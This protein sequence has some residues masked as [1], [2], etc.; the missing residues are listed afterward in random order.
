V[1]G[2]NTLA[3]LLGAL[4]CQAVVRM[5]RMMG[6]SIFGIMG[7]PM[8]GMM[9]IWMFFHHFNKHHKLGR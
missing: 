6:I 7:I 2:Y 5:F 1:D 9:S 3:L 4:W 8:F